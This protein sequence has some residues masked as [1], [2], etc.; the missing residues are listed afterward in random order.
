MNKNIPFKLG[1]NF[2]KIIEPQLKKPEIAILELISNSWDAYAH[3][4]QLQWPEIKGFKENYEKFTII[5]NGCG[6]SEEEFIERWG[7]IG[8]A[9]KDQLDESH[10]FREIIGKNGRGRLGLFC[11]SDRYT[12]STSKNGKVSTFEIKRD[13][14]NFAKINQITPLVQPFKKGSGIESGTYIECPIENDYI[15]LKTVEETITLRFGA[16]SLFN[17]YLNGKKINLFDFKDKS[18]YEIIHYKDNSI[19]IYKIPKN[20]SNPKL[21]SYEVVWWVKNRFVEQNTWESLNIDLDVSNKKENQYV[22]LICADFLEEEVRTDWS[23]FKDTKIIEDV[24]KIVST[25]INQMMG[26]VVNL[27][28]KERKMSLINRTQENIS[29]LT[30]IEQEKLGMYIDEIL[31]TCK[32][33]TL[34]DL[35]NIVEVLTKMELSN[36][37]YKFFDNIVNIQPEDLDKLTE[38]VEKWSINDAFIVLNELYAR[39]ELIKKLEILIENPQTK[40]VQQLQPL[41]KEGL[42]IFH[43]RYEGTIRFTSNKTMNRVI[44]ELLKVQDYHSE[45]SKKRPDFVVLENSTI[46]TF[47]SEY[48]ENDSEVIDG[49]EEILIIE[50]KREGIKITSKEIYQLMDYAKEIKS[51]YSSKNTKII[52]YVLG[53]AID[54]RETDTY[55]VGN[56]EIKAKQYDFIIKT[57]KNRTFNLLNKIKSVKGITDIGDE[58]INQVLK[59]DVFQKTFPV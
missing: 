1:K 15:D 23:G 40:E 54:P 33:I 42:W 51:G 16:D 7:Q 31:K 28:L 11:F 59:E 36:K 27:S 24:K 10:N 38:I 55:K 46:G 43:P 21:S 20:A 18:D 17:V 12:V 44:S 29:L 53:T 19:R 13:E 9:K 49:Y 5:D 8:Y 3:D 35:S 37:K 2:E 25:K 34:K 22:F 41:F 6:M 50:L 56:I 4:V 39:L 48:Y 45:N 26:E 32:N 58:E 14:K 57:A 52:G 30:P 47:T